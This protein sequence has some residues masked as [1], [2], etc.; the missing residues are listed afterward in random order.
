MSDREKVILELNND[1]RECLKAY[2][3]RCEE[4]KRLR[5]GLQLI[6][7]AAIHHGA[8]WCVAQARGYLEDLDFNQYPLKWQD[9]IGPLE[10]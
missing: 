1:Y 9:R 4:V 5:H 8:A 6:V 10:H 7:D 2:A 3:K